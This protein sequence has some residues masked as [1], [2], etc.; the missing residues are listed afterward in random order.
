MSIEDRDDAD[1][2]ESLIAEIMEAEAGGERV[3]RGALLTQ[4]PQH[5]DSL[6]DFFATHD[7]MKL[8]A[9]I[10]P[11]TLPPHEPDV[12]E[13]AIPPRSAGDDPT[14]LP[15]EP[16][17]TLSA[18]TVGDQ[19]RYF[20]DYELLEEIARG[21]MGV[22]FKA[23]QINLNRMVALKMILAGQFAGDEDVQRFYTEAEA[24]AQLDHPGIVP[25][26]EIGEHQ[27]QHYFSMGYIEGESLAHKVADGP[28]PPREAAELVKKVCE[29]IA[30]A[31]EHGVIHRD[32]K[33]ANILNDRNGQPKVTDF[34]LAKK[35]E[36]DSGLTGT[37]QILGTPA[38][39]PPEQASGKT[40]VGP[41]ADVYSLG[42][43]LYCLL[44]GRPPFQAA[45][46]M[47]TLLQVL[48]QE[49]VAPR[50][51]N[52]DVPK[53]LE[54]ICLKCLRKEPDRRYPHAVELAAD[55]QR[56][57]SGEPI[58]ARPVSHLERG[59]KWIRRHTVV[60]ILAASL[61][62]A[63]AAGSVT[64]I[65]FGV[66]SVTQRR[67]AET[68]LR[69]AESMLYA[70]DLA[71]AQRH[72]GDRN[73][74][75]AADVLID[76][77]PQLRGWEYSYL[78]SLVSYPS[79]ACN[80]G[81]TISQVGFVSDTAN[82]IAVTTRREDFSQVEATLNTIDTRTGR[83]L[84]AVT[85]Y[86]SSYQVSASP[87]GKWFRLFGEGQPESY[88]F[89]EDKGITSVSLP[90]DLEFESFS[91][92]NPNTVI[93]RSG[94][95]QM[96]FHLLTQQL[97]DSDEDSPATEQNESLPF[98]VTKQ[99]DV[100]EI[101]DTS[102]DTL[103]HA[104][105][106]Q[107]RQRLMVSRGTRLFRNNAPWKTDFNVQ[108]SNHDGTLAAITCSSGAVI[109]LETSTGKVAGVLDQHRDGP[110]RAEFSDD[111]NLL[112]TGGFDPDQTVRI[113]SIG[114]VRGPLEVSGQEFAVGPTGDL[115][116]VTKN[117]KVFVYRERQPG[118]ELIA[119]FSMASRV[120]EADFDSSGRWLAVR[121]ELVG[122]SKGGRLEIRVPELIVVLDTAG[123]KKVTEINLE[124]V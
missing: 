120:L 59:V 52:V 73:I 17:S 99:D 37:G 109:L 3:D 18:P 68:N 40:D 30:Y 62:F 57:L 1:P 74:Q 112:I 53:D 89:V 41:L 13:A 48:D 76:V 100:V 63:I 36:A 24:A 8:A 38:Y 110:P 45:R 69:R 4:Y 20:G 114:G 95:R 19:V 23:R 104:V 64:S 7:R 65:L 121:T 77:D 103:V 66:A 111:G 86:A 105:P 70:D 46:P 75:A 94:E 78:R 34:G 55:L 91:S 88:W 98:R 117:E 12:E 28:L 107:L 54:T 14:L 11:P 60:S 25:I 124:H 27:G 82:A 5:A 26:F 31:H 92:K 6:R 115:L 72:I 2:L 80:V 50:A 108:T 15:T 32:L 85:E 87:D 79:V 22:V 39:M 58:H 61:F 83:L 81:G 43:V 51:L 90:I 44:T 93:V 47:D 101:W 119:T 97:V 10:D 42:A 9:E 84:G 49:P 33:P 118:L 96:S 67:R 29:A 35:T 122:E 123:W 102:A 56:F 71:E 21:G 116:A 16:T 113:W 106:I